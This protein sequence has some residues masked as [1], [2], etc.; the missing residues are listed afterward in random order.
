[1]ILATGNLAVTR[2]FHPSFA[3]ERLELWKRKRLGANA[4]ARL[5]E[6]TALTYSHRRL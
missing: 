3:P 6:T 1:M 2:L 5:P 4:A